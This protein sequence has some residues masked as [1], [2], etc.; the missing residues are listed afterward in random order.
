VLLHT[1]LTPLS[2]F[3]V[4]C[5]LITNVQARWAT[6]QDADI[7]YIFYNRDIDVKADG[8]AHEIVEYQVKLLKES[9]RQAFAVQHIHF[10]ENVQKIRILDAKTIYQGKE[11]PI[12]QDQIEVKPLAS[13][14]QGFDQI[15]QVL[16][17]YPHAEVGSELY[18][19]FE[20]IESK[21]PIPSYYATA[22]LYSAHGIWKNSKVTLRSELPFFV[23]VNDP[24]NHLKIE[25]SNTKQAQVLKIQLTKPICSGMIHEPWNHILEEQNKTWV[26]V[27]TVDR[28]ESLAEKISKTYE[29]TAQE[30]L[31][32]LL[33]AIQQ[34]AA[35]ASKPVDQINTIT[36]ELA[37]KI[38]YMGD[39]STINGQYYPRPLAT[40]T[41]TGVGDC[42]DYAT[43]TAAILNT[44][45]Y[46]ANVALV[47][48][49]EIYA[50]IKR[51]PTLNHFN[52]AIVKAIDKNGQVF[53]IDPTN[54][55]SMA[56]GIFSDIAD[57][58]ALVLNSSNPTYERIPPVNKDHAKILIEQNV[59]LMSGALVKTSGTINLC[60]EIAAGLTSFA[61]SASE[62]MMQDQLLLQLCGEV[63]PVS[64]KVVLPKITSRNVCDLS[65]GFEY[66][67]EHNTLLTN[68][69]RALM[70]TSRRLQPFLQ[71]DNEQAGAVFIGHPETI[72]RKTIVQNA[73]AQ[74]LESLEYQVDSRWVR[75]KRTCK[76]IKEGIEIIERIEILKSM[77]SA[78]ERRSKEFQKLKQ[79]LKKYYE[80][81]AVIV[82]P[83]GKGT[84]STQAKYSN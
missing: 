46:K 43:V 6:P 64:K 55:I 60:G 1:K 3:V 21:Q 77:I 58:P 62:Q 22:V 50:P 5:F 24:G 31:P 38:N 8:K 30:A 10:N 73:Q 40:V 27:S 39:W 53:W 78:D 2:L 59:E 23:R 63:N 18:L 51:L 75:A 54:P 16:L 15:S 57:R 28:F 76:P 11:F 32:P 71:T 65:I 61:L 79:T 68:E 33:M 83:K 20:I 17:S 12:S 4:F 34:K 69:G 82:S 84:V 72:E 47:M 13:S 26:S 36:S 74:N 14:Y 67:Q 41:S 44:L 56:D 7:E 80:N 48:R 25:E 9:G 66:V 52:H 49:G 70:L 35:K 37:S 45:G 19:K 81:V 29:T 42:K